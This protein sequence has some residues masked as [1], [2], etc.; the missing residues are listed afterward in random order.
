MLNENFVLLGVFINL[1]GGISYIK[2]T[3]Q[4][5]IRP[6]RLSWGL[7]AVAVLIAFSAEISQGVG[8]QSLATFMVGFTPLLI[9]LASFVN[10]KAYWK[11]SRFDLLCGVLSIVGLILWQITKIGNIAIIFSIFADLM[12]GIPTLTKSYKYPETENWIEFMSSFISM[13][14]AML[15]IKIW[16]FA[17]YGFPLYIFLYDL[18]AVLLIKFKLGKRIESVKLSLKKP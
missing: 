9:F 14:I 11:I 5:K 6:N 7:W 1:L 13:G 18:T 10:K 12:A 16:T 2:D 8:I 3:V 4:G 17:Y 15:T